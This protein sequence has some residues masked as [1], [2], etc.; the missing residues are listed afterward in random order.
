MQCFITS[1]RSWS[2]YNCCFHTWPKELSQGSKWEKKNMD[3]ISAAG[4][5]LIL[6]LQP[7]IKSVSVV[8]VVISLLGQETETVTLKVKPEGPQEQRQKHLSA[9]SDRQD[10]TSVTWREQVVEVRISVRVESE[11]SDWG[12]RDKQDVVVI[13]LV[14]DSNDGALLRSPLRWCQ[15]AALMRGRRWCVC[16]RVHVHK[17]H[18]GVCNILVLSHSGASCGKDSFDKWPTWRACE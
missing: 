1:T 8:L 14:A 18:V 12:H 11:R 6:F 4:W 2:D 7:T 17:R 13:V 16:L 15:R 10:L 5:T 3:S 9:R